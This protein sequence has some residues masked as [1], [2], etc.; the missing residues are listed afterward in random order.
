MTK[1]RLRSVPCTGLTGLTM[2]ESEGYIRVAVPAHERTD[3]LSRAAHTLLTRSAAQ[4]ECCCESEG[5]AC[6]GDQD[7]C[8]H[9]IS[10]SSGDIGCLGRLTKFMPENAQS[11]S[12][13]GFICN[14]CGC[15]IHS[16]VKTRAYTCEACNFDVC[17]ECVSALFAKVRQKQCSLAGARQADPSS[18]IRDWGL[19]LVNP[20]EKEQFEANLHSWQAEA[21]A[22]HARR[23]EEIHQMTSLEVWQEGRDPAHIRKV[24]LAA[25]DKLCR[26]SKRMKIVRDRRSIGSFQFICLPAP[27][28]EGL[29]AARSILMANIGLISL[30][31][32]FLFEPRD[33]ARAGAVCRTWY[34]AANKQPDSWKRQ[35]DA[36]SPLVR[37]LKAKPGCKLSWRELFSQQREARKTTIMPD[38]REAVVKG[39][40]ALYLVG[41]EVRTNPQTKGPHFTAL[42]E[43]EPSNE[44]TELLY[45]YSELFDVAVGDGALAAN[46]GYAYNDIHELSEVGHNQMTLSVFLV[47]KQDGKI[48]TVVNEEHSDDIHSDD[49]ETFCTYTTFF[50]GADFVVRLDFLVN[51]DTKPSQCCNGNP[52]TCRMSFHSLTGRIDATDTDMEDYERKALVIS[53]P[54]LLGILERPESSF[55]WT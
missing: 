38:T 53:I 21:A 16:F 32:S 7:T 6:Q 35:C 18:T 50:A 23:E 26:W 41:V 17:E 43:L 55:L 33:L 34:A 51:F 2:R 27:S 48:L 45:S 24:E 9:N 10:Q 31:V 13:A 15:P 36:L 42:V 1:L 39:D 11:V 46:D 5:L 52:C 54:H 22:T 3:K 4:L 37:M 49:H 47:R 14:G 19:R 12:I 20:T 44:E 40:P 30:V 8:I 28:A 25:E 29:Q